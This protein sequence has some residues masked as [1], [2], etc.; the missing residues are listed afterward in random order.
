LDTPNRLVLFS[1]KEHIWKIADFGLTTEVERG[2]PGHTEHSRGTVG[3]RA[4]ELLVE[5]SPT[6][7][8]K[9]D[10]FALGCI[11]YELVYL[12]RCFTLDYYVAREYRSSKDFLSTKK[13]SILFDE[14]RMSFILTVLIDTLER[15]PKKRPTAKGIYDRFVPWQSRGTVA[16]STLGAVDDV[17]IA[18]SSTSLAP[19]PESAGI[20][21]LQ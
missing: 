21:T 2:I 19:I 4:P 5:H 3:Y 7:S 13:P 18:T 20:L 11:L 6:F 16:S 12:E 8:E 9:S 17:E 14:E 10:I 1:Q 15:D